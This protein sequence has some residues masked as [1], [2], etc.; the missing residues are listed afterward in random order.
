MPSYF[1]DLFTPE[2]WAAFLRHG[3]DV[4]GFRER[5]RHAAE[6][7]KVDDILICYVVRL[8]RWCGLLRVTSPVYVDRTP[9]FE[10]PDP[11]VMRFK[12]EP[13]VT[14]ELDRAIPI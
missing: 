4:S 3:A 7:I 9:I 12:V 13:L 6:R 5:Q 14:L 2:T 11:Y 8:S 1:T 10:D